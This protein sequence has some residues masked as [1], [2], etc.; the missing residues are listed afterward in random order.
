[1]SQYGSPPDPSQPDPQQPDAQQP[2]AQQPDAQQPD[3]YAAPPTPPD[4]YAAPPASPYGGSHAGAPSSQPPNPYGEPAPYGAGPQGGQSAPYIQPQQAVNPYAGPD[5][6]KPTFVFAGYA[7]WG[8]RLV[9]LIIDQIAGSLAA[10]P[11]WIGYVMLF[12]NSTSTPNADG[13][14]TMHFHNTA[15]SAIL[16]AIGV[17]T[18]LAFFIWNYCLRQGRTGATVGKSVM[19][20]RV[21][22]ADMQPIGGG[23]SF[24]RYVAQI[25]NS[26]PCY[27]GW[28][29]PLWDARNQTFADKVM[30]TFVIK[31]SEPQ[32]RAY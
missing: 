2:D 32:P 26:L 5:N 8:S 29:W 16:M 12:A 6:G 17:I 18:G 1:M 19:A 15:P 13:T 11:F 28:F 22:H 3:P 25:L 10:I 23:L 7:S 30:S 20:I 14:S 24:V 31:A 21:V 9:A 4:P 27:I